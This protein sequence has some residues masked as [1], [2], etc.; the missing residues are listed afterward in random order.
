M[1][2][3]TKAL[4]QNAK[5]LHC[6]AY[7]N[8]TVTHA[9]WIPPLTVGADSVLIGILCRSHM[10]YQVRFGVNGGVRVNIN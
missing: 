9:P 5:V 10:T 2:H 1:L 7:L 8:A 3:S 6:I 4:V